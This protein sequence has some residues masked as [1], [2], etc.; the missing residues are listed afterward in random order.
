MHRLAV[1]LLN[2]LARFSYIVGRYGRV[3]SFKRAPARR[4]DALLHI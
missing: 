4:R 1:L 3:Q 2:L